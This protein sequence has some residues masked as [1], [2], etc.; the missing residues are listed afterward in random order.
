[1]LLMDLD[2]FKDI[3]DALGHDVG[4]QLLRLV[5][6]RLQARLGDR[7]TVA[8]LG[9]D[10]FAVLLPNTRTR[11]VAVAI[12]DDLDAAMD[13]PIPI[14]HLRLSARVSIGV[15]LAPEHGNDAKTLIQRADV[16]MYVA[17]TTH[18]G[19]RVYTP[20]DD[21]NSPRR[22][23]MA[24]DLREAIQRHDIVVVFQPKLETATGVVVGA[25]ALA[26]WHHPIHG[27]VPPDEFI[28]LAE[29]SGLIRPLTL[30]V[31]EVSLRRCATWRRM[32]HDMH[33][34]VNL[35]PNSLQEAD[36]PDIVARL[37]GQ[38]G[39]PAS[40]LTL[41][42]TES[43]IMADPTGALVTL[44]RLHALGVKLAIDDFGT[45]YSSLGR[46]REL[47][48]HEMK[49]DRSF[50]QRIAID[51]RDRAV[52]RSAVQ[53]GHALDL[54]VVAEGVEDEETLLHLRQ[55]GCNLVQGYYISKPL[56]ADD[57]ADWLT[58]R[59]PLLGGA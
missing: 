56:P 23:A 22:L 20:D 59:V 32:G 4:D 49:I 36:L 51:H 17:K 1:M 2:R 42:I 29:S 14:G 15:A 34:A 13:H 27:F 38:S 24:A 40:A 6:E 7:G 9:G 26:R 18:S 48:I 12:A 28:P 58:A 53:L 10:E 45:G 25:E 35:S 52:V 11:E 19:V 5:G 55:E 8:R 44:D 3:N 57:F 39:V 37:L 54:M 46:L 31:L 47:P 43:S 21:R 41:E 16:A 50:V 33:V 30:H